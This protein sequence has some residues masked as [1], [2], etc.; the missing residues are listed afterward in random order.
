MGIVPTM[1]DIRNNEHPEQLRF[2]RERYGKLV[3]PGVPDRVMVARSPVYG[4]P[5]WEYAMSDDAAIQL[6]GIGE[7]VRVYGKAR[8]PQA[9]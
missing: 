4:K 6:R 2:M 3:F 1:Y 5:I 8:A 7:K 9:T